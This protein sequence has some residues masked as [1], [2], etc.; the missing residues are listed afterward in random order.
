MDRSHPSLMLDVIITSAADIIRLWSTFRPVDRAFLRLIIGDLLLLV[1][2]PID[3]TLLITTIS[4]WGR[5][6]HLTHFPA[7]ST[8]ARSSFVYSMCFDLPIMSTPIGSSL[9]KDIPMEADRT[10]YRFTWADT[11]ASFPDR[12]SHLLVGF[13]RHKFLAPQ[14]MP[15]L[16][17]IRVS[18]AYSGIPFGHPPPPTAQT[19][20]N[21]IDFV[22]FT[23][24]EG[25]RP[26]SG[27]LAS[28]FASGTRANGRPELSDPTD[29][30]FGGRGHIILCNDIRTGVHSVRD[31]LPPSPAPTA[32]P[33]PPTAFLSMDSAMHTLPPLA[34]PV[35]SPIYT[36]P[37][38]TIPLIISA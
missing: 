11:T 28:H 2:S 25:M 23:A 10:P 18:T 7:S 13:A 15:S 16:T 32:V 4:F 35:Q 33:L 37:P 27:F 31:P 21:F 6:A 5:S 36:M 34:I 8:S 1:D 12:D 29:P 3:W 22:R 26:K 38:P 20:S 14:A 17:P 9:W 24:L 19:T 30:C